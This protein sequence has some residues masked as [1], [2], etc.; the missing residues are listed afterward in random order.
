M[1]IFIYLGLLITSLVL[2]YGK[3]KKII[4]PNTIFTV[5]W[6]SVGVL[7]ICNNLPIREPSI[8]IHNYIIMSLITFN[9][10]YLSFTKGSKQTIKKPKIY[11]YKINYK[12]IYLMNLIAILIVSPYTIS[13]LSTIL[14]S[15]FANVRDVT[16]VS[17]NEGTAIV[18]IITRTIPLSIFGATY[19]IAAIQLARNKYKLLPIALIDILISTVT[20]GGRFAILNFIVYYF[21]SYFLVKKDISIKI[22]KRYIVIGVVGLII[23][24]SLR[25]SG[26][27]SVLDMGILYFVGSLSYLEVILSRPELYG[28]F[29]SPKYGYL[30]FGFIIEPIVL[31]LKVIGLDLKV[32]SYF[33]N[34]YA[35]PWANIGADGYNIWYNNNT[36]M[37]YTF[38]LDFGWI[39][40][41]VGTSFIAILAAKAQNSYNKDSNFRS[42]CILVYM[43]GVIMSSTIKYNLTSLSTSIIFILLM[44][45]VKKVKRVST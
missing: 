10:I 34:T 26:G 1:F 27:M 31:A 20:F 29:Q 43:I 37:I 35:Q 23:V 16:Y 13:A 28:L 22:K 40:I 8:Q 24:T 6:S 38:L 9:L 39:G 17:I 19:V 2:T 30:T 44:I 4:Q 41:L 14:Q 32:P 33:F 21:S 12:L 42:L 7:A 36:T 11:E 5:L 15:G 18:A 25:N 3:F 45:F